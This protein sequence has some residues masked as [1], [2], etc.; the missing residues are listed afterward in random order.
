MWTTREQANIT[1]LTVAFRN[2]ANAPDSPT[3]HITIL[4][5]FR[6]FVRRVSIKAAHRLQGSLSLTHSLTHTHH[7]S[8]GTRSQEYA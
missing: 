6:K 4:Q 8:T 3:E 5:K 2:S 7:V 1:K